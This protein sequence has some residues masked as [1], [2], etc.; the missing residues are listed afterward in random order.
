MKNKVILTAALLSAACL[1]TTGIISYAKTSDSPNTDTVSGIAIEN[2]ESDE[3]DSII[4]DTLAEPIPSRTLKKAAAY[5]KADKNDI[6]HMM[7]NSIDYYDKV[8]GTIYFPTGDI[9][10]VNSVQFQSVLS[11]TTAYSHYSQVYADNISNYSMESISSEAEEIEN[12]IYD[13]EEYCNADES[14]SMNLIEKSYTTKVGDAI[15]LDCVC[16]IPDNE[17]ITIAE[18]GE[19]CYNYRTNPTNVPEASICIFPQE[20][21]F[22]FLA[23]QELWDIDGIEEIDGNKGYHIIGTTTK[24]Y[25]NKI[26]V[27]SFEFVVDTDTGVLLKYVGYDSNGEISDYMYTENIKFEDNA[28]SVKSY[29]QTL[30]ADF[31][32][33]W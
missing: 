33:N 16:E 22:G 17:R 5:D 2:Q 28:N 29:S 7:L 30:T 10:L 25:G 31:Q 11:E 24:E 8:S 13:E 4:K 18:D 19:P 26:N 1:T 3:T 15:S 12:L 21:A 6:Y 14:V 23:D 32:L 27:S 9:N 20:M